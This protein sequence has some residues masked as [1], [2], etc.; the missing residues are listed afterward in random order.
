M[1]TLRVRGYSGDFKAVVPCTRMVTI[2]NGLIGN[3]RRCPETLSRLLILLHGITDPC[4]LKIENRHLDTNCAALPV[5]FH[6]AQDRALIV[7]SAL[8]GNQHDVRLVDLQEAALARSP[9]GAED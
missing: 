7:L 8:P 6:K 1:V 3:S 4:A 5:H 2:S 9:A